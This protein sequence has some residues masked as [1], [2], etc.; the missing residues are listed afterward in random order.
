MLGIYTGSAINTLNE[1]FPLKPPWNYNLRNQQEFTIKP[2]KTVYY[3][4]NSLAY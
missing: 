4:F 1:V 2:M 3:D